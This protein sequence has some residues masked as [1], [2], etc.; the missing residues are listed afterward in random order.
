MS[1][2]DATV[3]DNVGTQPPDLLS[4][5]AMAEDG[6]SMSVLRLTASGVTAFSVSEFYCMCISEKV[7]VTSP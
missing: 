7:A 4:N 5:I 3:T 2:T 1:V 6:G